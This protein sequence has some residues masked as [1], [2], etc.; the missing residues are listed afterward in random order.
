MKIVMVSSEIAPYSKTGGLGEA[1]GGLARE[2]ARRGHQVFCV[3]PY[4]RC[5]WGLARAKASGM[6]LTVPIG[7]KQLT[8]DIYEAVESVSR[9]EQGRGGDREPVNENLNLVFV[10]RDEYFDRSELYSTPER[11]YEDNAERFIFLS[12]VAV[13]WL[14]VRE[15][16]PDAVHCHDWQTALVPLLV[17]LEEQAQHVRIATR[18]VFTIHNLA[19]QGIFW[20]L[21]FPMTNLPWQFFT[22]DGLEFYGQ[23]N[24]L[25]AGIVFTDILTTVSPTYAS[26]IQTPEGGFGLENAVK[27]RA[28]RLRG[29]LNGVDYAEWNPETDRHI[30]RNYSA[31][32]L[33]GKED[34]KRALL[35][36]FGLDGDGN[37][38]VIGMVSRLTGQKGIELVEEAFDRILG[39]GTRLV[40]LGKGEL[41]FERFWHDAAKRHPKL[42]GVRIAQDE[43]LAHQ[44]EAGADMLLMP[45]KFE[46]CGLN[47]MYSLRYGTVPVVRATGGLA[48]TVR[49]RGPSTGEGNGFSFAAYDANDLVACLERVVAMYRDKPQWERLQR[50]GMGCD[51]S[52][53]KCVEQYLELY[54]K[55]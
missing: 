44:I 31:S 33:S 28:E 8:A 37:A 51:F 26:E 19:Y 18:T 7:S 40:V 32:D 5:S 49:E 16:Y 22:P 46:P 15:L 9:R 36:R 54:E 14:R 12:K 20:S 4:Y 25:K 55:G 21:D 42:V 30:A 29:I 34:C 6:K 45:S 2:L 48:D 35:E 39:L 41:K 24:L 50:N 27:A 47:Q 52:W 13:E 11:D 1:V 17:R 43:A 53:R 23:M 10:R 3:A 38:P